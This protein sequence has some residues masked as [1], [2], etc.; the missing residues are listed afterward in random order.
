MKEIVVGIESKRREDFDSVYS[1]CRSEM[2]KA[3][4]IYTHSLDDAEDIAQEALIRYYIY[5]A[6]RPVE[7]PRS[8]LLVIAKNLAMNYLRHAQHERVLREEESM[9]ILLESVEDTADVFVENMWRRE[10]LDYTDRVLEA[11]RAKNK[12][13]YDALIYAYCMEMPRQDIADDMGISLDALMSMLGRAKKWIRKHYK[14][15][16]D[17]IIGA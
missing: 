7:N 9:E 4:M 12:K 2:L 16:Y 15:E 14:D 11:V 3:A 6:H 8:W 5:S 13:W 10:I 17:H 1:E